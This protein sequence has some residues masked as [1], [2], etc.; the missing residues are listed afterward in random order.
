MRRYPRP[1][2]LTAG[3]APA[4][5]AALPRV[6]W[7]Y[8]GGAAL[9]AAGFADF[10]L[11]AYHFQRAGTVFPALTPVFYAVVM[12]V[13]GIGSPAQAGCSTGWGSRWSYVVV[14]RRRAY[15]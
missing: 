15:S 8:V 2:D 6:F 14:L 11:I 12:A 9:A 13:S 7:I 3:P 5:T 1:Q 10:P 4:T